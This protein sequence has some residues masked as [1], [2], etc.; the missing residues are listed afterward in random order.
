MDLNIIGSVIAGAAAVVTAIIAMAN[1][2]SASVRYDLWVKVLANAQND[3]Q[4]EVAAGR[5]NFYF[6]ELAVTEL[7]RRRRTQIVVAGFAVAA[8][9][10]VVTVLGIPL[11]QG[12]EP[13]ALG[14]GWTLAII[15]GVTYV[16]GL[17][18]AGF[19]PDRVRDEQRGRTTE[20]SAAA[21]LKGLRPLRW[22]QRRDTTT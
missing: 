13:F 6:I 8:L 11:S 9:G 5:V 21:A 22:W 17:G 14:A 4:R 20:A 19:G 16:G 1:Q 7:T 10:Y 3:H 12:D 18:W 15:G 2:V